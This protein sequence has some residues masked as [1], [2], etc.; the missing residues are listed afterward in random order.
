VSDDGVGAVE[1]ALVPAD[2]DAGGVDDVK[3]SE[4]EVAAG[5]ASATDVEEDDATMLVDVASINQYISN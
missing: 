4:I 1:L 2:A 3:V 5:S